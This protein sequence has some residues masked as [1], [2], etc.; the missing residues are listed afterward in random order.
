[1]ERRLPRPLL[2]KYAAMRDREG[3]DGLCYGNQPFII[4]GAS[5]DAENAVRCYQNTIVWVILLTRE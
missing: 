1:M 4:E 5:R 3:T 2:G